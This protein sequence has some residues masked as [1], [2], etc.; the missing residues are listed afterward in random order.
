MFAVYDAAD[1]VPAIL[2]TYRTEKIVSMS[3][4]AEALATC[5]E[6]VAVAAYA[7]PEA[8][9]G[10]VTVPEP[11]LA[12]RRIPNCSTPTAEAV[13]TAPIAAIVEE[14]EESVAPRAVT[15]YPLVAFV[16]TENVCAIA[17]MSPPEGFVLDAY[18]VNTGEAIPKYTVDVE[19]LN[20]IV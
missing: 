6:V 14:A 7:K 13:L 11:P 9:Y 12:V 3:S 1:V 4:P 15:V 10:E 18:R 2:A 19:T 5:E 16:D 8:A 17:S 20:V